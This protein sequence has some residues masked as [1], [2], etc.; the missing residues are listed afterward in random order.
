MDTWIIV[1]ICVGLFGIGVGALI[2]S[3][4][5]VKTPEGH[6]SIISHYAGQ[7]RTARPIYSLKKIFEKVSTVVDLSQR[8]ENIPPLK[9]KVLKEAGKPAIVYLSTKEMSLA[10]QIGFKGVEHKQAMLKII[11][12]DI[13]NL[14]IQDYL[15]KHSLPL[16]GPLA[17]DALDALA[18]Q[19]SKEKI[20]NYFKLCKDDQ[21]DEKK[22]REMLKDIV[23]S[24][25]RQETANKGMSDVLNS[26]H[27]LMDK[28]K[29]LLIRECELRD[30]PI[31]INELTMQDTIEILNKDLAR[32]IESQAI[33]ETQKDAAKGQEELELLKA[34]REKK[35][36]LVEAQKQ[37]ELAQKDA[38]K[39]KIIANAL[40]ANNGINDL[41]PE[42]VADHMLKREALKTL[43]ELAKS[44]NKTFVFSGEQNLIAQLMA[45]TG[46]KNEKN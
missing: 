9:I 30:L 34:E 44:Q 20:N 42:H 1:L 6:L 7:V 35:V 14:D 16:A 33:V 21:F 41:E 18:K 43:G 25:F 27:E 37:I 36:A 4:K 15:S 39:A 32:A 3:L 8:T 19:E 12:D 40:K 46:G 26:Q 22:V 13:G 28:V 10:F 2:I 17:K 45:L 23:Q 11:N 24:A 5:L 38:E 29:E 31:K